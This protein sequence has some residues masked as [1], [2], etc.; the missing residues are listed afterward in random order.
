MWRCDWLRTYS[1][2][3]RL[4]GANSA[5]PPFYEGLVNSRGRQ[6][7]RLAAFFRRSDELFAVL[8]GTGNVWLPLRLT[9]HRATG[10]F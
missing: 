9:P 7:K 4:L 10:G 2:F 1:R 3:L 6:P 8:S 5:P